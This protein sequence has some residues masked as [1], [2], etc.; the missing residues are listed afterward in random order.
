MDE[1]T[2]VAQEQRLVEPRASADVASQEAEAPDAM[3]PLQPLE[4]CGLGT[5]RMCYIDNP[6]RRELRAARAR[7]N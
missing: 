3:P 7:Q 5:I 6:R 1:R 2:A 4:A